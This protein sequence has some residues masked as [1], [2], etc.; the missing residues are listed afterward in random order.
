MPPRPSCVFGILL[1]CI[2]FPV[3]NVIDFERFDGGRSSAFSIKKNEHIIKGVF[4]HLR[5]I[6]RY[7]IKFVFNRLLYICRY[8]GIVIIFSHFKYNIYFKGFKTLFKLKIE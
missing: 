4:F 3:F 6:N 1:F 2:L 7:I 8:T 5:N